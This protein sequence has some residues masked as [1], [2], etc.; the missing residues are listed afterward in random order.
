MSVA[1]PLEEYFQ[2]AASWDADRLAQ[3]RRGTRNAWR[4]AA[5]GWTCAVASSIALVLL[6]PLKRVDPFV[7]RVDT[8][9]GIVDVVPVYTGQA[10]VE[11]TV[12][13]YFLTHYTQR[14]STLQ[15]RD[16]RERL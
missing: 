13:R 4:V 1:T 16:R 15:L 11:Q 8:S 9:T 14:L 2:E 6:T 10:S 12:T 5:A 7:V 3:A